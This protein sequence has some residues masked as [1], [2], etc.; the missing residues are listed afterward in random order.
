MVIDPGWRDET[1]K[2]IARN[3]R[4][5]S[6]G[7][8]IS[9]DDY[10]GTYIG[11]TKFT[12]DVTTSLFSE[13]EAMV[14]EGLVNL[15]FNA[16]VQRLVYRGLRVNVSLTGG[17]PWAEIDDPADFEYACAHVYPELPE[18]WRRHRLVADVA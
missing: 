10:T 14:N 1:M 16:A 4:I 8:H 11:F 12:Q 6:M 9:R 2:V 5:V 13:I 18:L 15:F 3:R 7:K 17:L